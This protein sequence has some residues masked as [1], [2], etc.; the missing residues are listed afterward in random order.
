MN[1]KKGRRKAD[2]L[3]TKEPPLVGGSVIP[4]NAQVNRS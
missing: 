4:K 3:E 1:P 2:M